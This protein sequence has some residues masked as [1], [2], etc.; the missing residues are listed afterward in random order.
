MTM[1][2]LAQLLIFTGLLLLLAWPLGLY[3]ARVFSGER[4][5]LTPL[6]KP[7]EQ[8]AYRLMGID[9]DQPQGWKSWSASLL[10][11]SLVAIGFLFLL[12]ML[13]GWL[14]ANPENLPP[15][16]VHSAINV[17]VSFITNTNWQNYSGE[18]T[19]SYLTQMMGLGVLNFLSAALGI[20]VLIAL[21]R[22]ITAHGTGHLGNF[23]VDLVRCH[24]YV[25]LP[26]ATL[27]AL[28]LIS[29]GVVQTFSPYTKVDT[30]IA[31][32][33]ADLQTG[34]LETLPTQQTIPLGPAASQIAIKQ[35]GTNGGG[36][37]GT[38]SA[39]PLENP[40]ALT[41]LLQTLAILLIP[42]ALTFTFGRMSRNPGQ[43]W[44]FLGVM[45]TFWFTAVA[46]VTAT[47]QMGS[48]R[49][50]VLGVDQIASSEQPGGNMEGK[51]ARLGIGQSSLWAV[52]ATVT[53][54]GSVNSMHASYLPISTAVI[55][56]GMQIGGPVFGAVGGGLQNLLLFTLLAVFLA[57][58]M[59]GRTPSFMGKPFGMAEIRLATLGI[60][61]PGA[62]VL[63]GITSSLLM[64]GLTDHMTNGGPR[65]FSELLYAY[66]SAGFTNGSAFAGLNADT[67]WFNLSL[68]MVMLI[69]RF[70]PMLAALAIAGYLAQKSATVDERNSVRTTTPLFAL[71]LILTFI[72]IGGLG[73]LPAQIAGPILEA[74]LLAHP[75]AF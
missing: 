13:Q 65:G 10:V 11:M 67:P 43:G 4:V 40:T 2:A 22:A 21:I 57:S 30:V 20:V 52:S 51:E 72:V 61:L 6:L 15:P 17:A 31:H 60:L 47:E 5:L 50:E 75:E 58:L 12:Q 48:P 44:L 24:L 56:S 18:V 68:A 55:M 14:P 23:W 66:S 53:S 38:N 7:V 29:Q 41:N 27:L 69:G 59:V 34:H 19:Y 32:A 26:L 3:M 1:I 71:L 49:L 63:L 28:V 62:A 35:L 74:V 16:A 73:F 37:F 25:L 70:A 42:A 54:N 64:P 45:L 46:I 9:P 8:A 39:H 33:P 36:F